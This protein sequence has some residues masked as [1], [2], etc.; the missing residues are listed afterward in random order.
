MKKKGGWWEQERDDF[1]VHAQQLKYRWNELCSTMQSHGCAVR[2]EE[3]NRRHIRLVHRTD[4]SWT[5]E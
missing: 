5:M 4:V 1:G 3:K 2:V